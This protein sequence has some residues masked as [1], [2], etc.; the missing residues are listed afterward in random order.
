MLRSRKG[1][2]VALQWLLVGVVVIWGTIT[3][4]WRASPTVFWTLVA[5]SA[6]GNAA[7]MRMPLPYFYQ[8]THWMHLFI[9]DTVFV[10]AAIYC[11]VRFDPELYLPYF[12]I[13]LIAALTRS[14]ARALVVAVGVSVVY[15]FLDF[16]L[17]REASGMTKLDSAY[18]IRLPF[19]FIIALFTSYLANAARLQQEAQQSS[20][21]LAEQVRS[22]QQLAAGIAHEVRNPLTAIS[23]SLQ[24]IIRRLPPDGQEREIAGEALEQVGRL[25]RIVQETLEFARPPSLKAGWL[26]LNALL[27]RSV[28]ESMALVPASSPT[29]TPASPSGTPAPAGSISVRMRVG[30][31]ALMIRGDGLLLQQAIMNLLRNA[32]EAMPEGGD[33]DLATEARTVRGQEEIMVR[34]ADSG[35]GFLPHQMD[36]LFQPFYTT[37]PAGT[38]LGL[39]LA[40]KYV[41][42]HG[43]DIAVGSRPGKGT[44]VRIMLPV[45]APVAQD[46]DGH[47]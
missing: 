13:V 17:W 24:T 21:I 42:A 38:G 11:M 8:P 10:G 30:P 31:Q 41:R 6:V 43:G 28:Q 40:R 32:L 15:V 19:F 22:L 35:P 5:L 26:D 33:L 29:G 46:A 20:R 25:S 14:F 47:A 39:C 23:N 34:I 37:K 18:L 12:L 3:G 45:T 2:V 7:L 36:R 4:A 1:Y 16:T 44:E 9:A 27:A